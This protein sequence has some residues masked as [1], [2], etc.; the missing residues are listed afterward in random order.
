MLRAVVNGV[1]PYSFVCN[2]GTEVYNAY[3]IC[4]IVHEHN[5]NE[6]TGCL[7]QCLWRRWCSS[8]K[9][10]PFFLGQHSHIDHP[11]DQTMRDKCGTR[12]TLNPGL[13]DGEKLIVSVTILNY[14]WGSFVFCVMARFSHC[15]IV[16]KAA[17][18]L[19]VFG[20][21]TVSAGL[22]NCICTSNPFRDG[23]HRVMMTWEIWMAAAMH[24]RSTQTNY[25]QIR[26]WKIWKRREIV[27]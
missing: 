27:W 2:L 9:S 5:R 22:E 10:I 19:Y 8:S 7:C 20:C 14:F 26:Q 25:K 17:A 6:R 4:R 13:S 15:R 23:S 18:C 11:F 24:T 16:S 12:W 3:P 1:V 21:Q